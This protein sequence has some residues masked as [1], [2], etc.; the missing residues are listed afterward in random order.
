MKRRSP[1]WGAIEA[2]IVA[3]RRTA[4]FKDAA[5]QLA[6]SPAAFSR[7]IQML[8]DHVGVKL[9]NRGGQ[10]PTLTV[11]GERYLQRLE[12]SYEAMR[13]AT[14]WMAPNAE[15]RALR[16]GVSQSFAVSW[17]VP[18]LPDFYQKTQGI[19]LII[20]TFADHVDLTGGA[21][22]LRILYGHGDWS[23][24]SS[25]KLF[26]LS[27]FV[28][29]APVLLN[30]QSAPQSIDDLYQ[31]PLLE[32]VQPRNQW[33]EWL[34]QSGC[35][36]PLREP[37]YFDSAQVMYEA[38]CQGLGVALGVSPLVDSFI[39]SGRLHKA[40]ESTQPLSGAYYI[41]ALPEVRRHPAVQVLWHWLVDSLHR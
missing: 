18:R 36:M 15:R 9:F 7:R 16:L 25:H 21:A 4:S 2:F 14:E 29:S 32:L 39:N 30:G 20:Q 34:T 40:F 22:D 38:A 31:V 24:F 17:L 28:V 12:P 23:D 19:E 10:T 8:E 37:Q 33:S 1:P 11:A 26:D 41:A 5:A 6:L 35:T 3:G 13:T 27:A